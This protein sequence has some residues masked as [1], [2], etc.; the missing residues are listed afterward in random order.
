LRFDHW[1]GDIFSNV[2]AASLIM[3]GPR[4]VTAVYVMQHRV[5]L[6]TSGLGNID[7][8]VYNG[9]DRLGTANDSAP[10]SIFVDD[11]PFALHT[12]AI[13]NGASGVRYV[14]LNFSPAPPAELQAA[15]ATTAI[16]TTQY[17]LSVET[18]PTFAAPLDSSLTPSGWQ[19]AGT[20]VSLSTDAF[21]T[22][23]L[24]SR[25]RFDHWS[26]DASG[27]ATGTSIAMNGP[28]HVIANYITQ[29]L[30]S[31]L[32]TGLGV[33]NTHLFNGT[34]LLGTAN[35]SQPLILFLDEGPLAL[36]ADANVSQADGTQY[37]FQG[38]TP[39]APSQLIQPFTTTA[40]YKTVSQILDDGITNGG[41][42]GPGA[43]G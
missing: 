18:S 34:L 1:G 30:L 31:V 21:I 26:G 2:P 15:F 16:Y 41:F 17:F 19:A 9:A 8:H 37:F 38:F 3:N 43:R 11:G 22:L 24:G 39:A 5:T 36:T 42:R 20:T 13:V 4:S 12:D 27:T 23:G 29:H 33:N 7:T 25:L 32:T 6:N 28:K 35:D 40:T 10:L 14:F